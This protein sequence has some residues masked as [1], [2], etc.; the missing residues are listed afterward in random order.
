MNRTYKIVVVALLIAIGF[1]F[2]YWMDKP[3]QAD[4]SHVKGSESCISCHE[5]SITQ[6]AW[7]GIPDWHDI[8]FCNPILNAENRKSHCSTAHEHRTQCMTCHV[9]NFQ[10]KCANCHTQNEWE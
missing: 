9:S 1:S 3:I 5:S 4:L 6:E 8:E 2:S 10:I 7:E